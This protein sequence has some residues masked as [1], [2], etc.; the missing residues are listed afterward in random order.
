MFPFFRTTFGSR[1]NAAQYYR[2]R[3]VARSGGSI[4]SEIALYRTL[5]NAGKYRN[6]M[7]VLTRLNRR[8][9][10]M[11]PNQK[12]TLFGIIRKHFPNLNNNNY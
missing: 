2:R 12:N 8:V 6:A 4:T 1:N 7:T 5:M 3:N 11:T 9:N 10:Q